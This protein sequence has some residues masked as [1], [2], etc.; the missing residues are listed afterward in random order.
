MIFM[1]GLGIALWTHVSNKAA[2]VPTTGLSPE[3]LPPAVVYHGLK[4][5]AETLR[6]LSVH[7]TRMMPGNLS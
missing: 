6:S 4:P 2:T 5:A 3:P 1:V 7:C